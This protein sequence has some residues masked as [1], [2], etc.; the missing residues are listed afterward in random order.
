MRLAGGGD[1]VQGAAGEPAAEHMVD[2]LDPERHHA[3]I[4][5]EPGRA[6]QGLQALTQFLE[7]LTSL[8][9]SGAIRLLTKPSSFFY[10]L[11]LF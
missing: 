6:L 11:Y 9:R 2:R 8:W 1:L 10:V 3:R 4:V 5:L 7:H